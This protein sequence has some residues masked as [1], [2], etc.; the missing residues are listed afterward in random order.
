MSI[1]YLPVPDLR[2]AKQVVA[3]AGTGHCFLKLGVSSAI[4]GRCFELWRLISP[5]RESCASELMQ[6]RTLL[7]EQLLS[8]ALMRRLPPG[9]GRWI[10]HWIGSA[11]AGL[12]GICILESSLAA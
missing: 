3:I 7:L 5:Y 1:R 10:Q 6:P 11:I 12:T 4:L 2:R 9:T 8:S